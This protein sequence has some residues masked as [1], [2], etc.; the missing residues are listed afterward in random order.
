MQP[1]TNY[2]TIAMNNSLLKHQHRDTIDHGKTIYY[3][4]HHVCQEIT[5]GDDK[6]LL[7]MLMKM[8]KM[9]L[10][11]SPEGGGVY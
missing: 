3:I 4:I 10:M 9:V 6:E 5:E 2:I 11:P 1:K 7:Q 8:M